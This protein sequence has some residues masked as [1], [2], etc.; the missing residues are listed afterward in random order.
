MRA[1]LGVHANIAV[2]INAIII[3]K[4][5]IDTN[6]VTTTKI[7]TN[8]TRASANKVVNVNTSKTASNTRECVLIY[9]QLQ[10]PT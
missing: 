8:N 1:M 10:M 7:I 9:Y 2:T 4:R 6:V 5:K 3:V